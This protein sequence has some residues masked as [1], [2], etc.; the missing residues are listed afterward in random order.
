MTATEGRGRPG[1]DDFLWLVAY[2]FLS[3]LMFLGLAAAILGAQAWAHTKYQ[4][5][6]SI[7]VLTM[8][9]S[10]LLGILLAVVRIMGDLEE[11]AL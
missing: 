6:P 7:L 3:A 5:E 4:V 8:I 9:L 11:D 10:W 1:I 2:A